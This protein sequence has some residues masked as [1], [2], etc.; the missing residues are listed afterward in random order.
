MVTVTN[1]EVA[2]EVGEVGSYLVYLSE[3]KITVV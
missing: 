1:A 2:V 3:V